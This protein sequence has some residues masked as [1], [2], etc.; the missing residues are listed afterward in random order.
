MEDQEDEINEEEKQGEKE[1]EDEPDPDSWWAHLTPARVAWSTWPPPT[2]III[3]AHTT[4]PHIP[5]LPLPLPL[6]LLIRC[7]CLQRLLLLFLLP[8]LVLPF[9]PLSPPPAPSP[10]SLR[11]RHPMLQLPHTYTDTHIPAFSQSL[12]ISSPLEI[13]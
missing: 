11:V 3:N 5:H 9:L 1:E 6:I 12:V 2:I 13:P 4:Q 7:P 10:H 8:L